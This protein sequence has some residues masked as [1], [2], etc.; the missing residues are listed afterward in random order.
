MPD[1]PETET[2]RFY[3]DLAAWW[4][5]ISPPDEYV[6]EAAFAA[7]LLGSASIPVTNVLELGS[8]GGHSAVHPKARFAMA[9]TDLSEEMLNVSR[10]LNPECDHHRGDMRTVRLG[11]TFD[12]VFVHDAVDYMV[13]EVDLRQAIETAFVHCRPG[14]VA[15]FVPDAI[16]ETFEPATGHGG[17]DDGDGR[18]VR[19][20]D[21]TWD[22]DPQDTWTLTEY[23]FLLRNADGAVEAVHETHRLGLFCREDWLRLLAGAGFAASVV[24]EVTSEDRTS[25]AF[26][27]GHRPGEQ[28]SER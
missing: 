4:P 18:G 6:E 27:V 20:L 25:R 17:R 24:T 12:A 23:A 21:W 26:F 1:N 28:T 5:L 14:G 16:R 19:Y 8:G 15:V 11:R 13:S 2:Y 10:R 3:G 9:L 22:P 7:S